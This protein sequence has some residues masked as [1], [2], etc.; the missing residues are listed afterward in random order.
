MMNVS[1]LAKKAIGKYGLSTCLKAF[2]LHQQGN[3]ASTVGFELGL[4]TNQA[5]AAINAGREYM[6]AGRA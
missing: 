4:K 6:K 2:E 3:G 5:D 1:K